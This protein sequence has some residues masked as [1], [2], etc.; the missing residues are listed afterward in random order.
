[1]ARIWA[2]V[3]VRRGEGV[4]AFEL[5]SRLNS[6]INSRIIVKVKIEIRLRVRGMVRA[7]VM[8]RDTFTIRIWFGLDLGLK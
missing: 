6:S 8:L 1:M 2:R 3:G 4:F 7:S 5:R